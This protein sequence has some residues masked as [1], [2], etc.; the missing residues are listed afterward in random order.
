MIDKE[1]K[2]MMLSEVNP[3]FG[4]ESCL[5]NVVSTSRKLLVHE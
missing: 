1:K 4:G 2:N 3:S 5:H